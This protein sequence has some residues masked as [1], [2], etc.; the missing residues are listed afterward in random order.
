MKEIFALIVFLIEKLRVLQL[1]WKMEG[2]GID[3]LKNFAG[4]L[5]YTVRHFYQ[6]AGFTCWARNVR[7][8]PHIS[9]CFCYV[10]DFD[11]HALFTEVFNVLFRKSVFSTSDI[12]VYGY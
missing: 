2:K 4:C 11:N 9:K 6:N 1:K 8:P 7:C 5:I 3:E 10:S 12:V